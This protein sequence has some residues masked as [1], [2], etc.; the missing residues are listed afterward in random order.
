[1]EQIIWLH[2][3][4]LLILNIKITANILKMCFIY[5]YLSER[6]EIRKTEISHPL[7]CPLNSC[8]S[9]NWARLRPGSWEL[10]AILHGWQGPNY[11]DHHHHLLPPR[12]LI[13]KKLTG[14]QPFWY[15]IW[16]SQTQAPNLG[17]CC[18]IYIP[19]CSLHHTPVFVEQSQLLCV[20]FHKYF[21]IYI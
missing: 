1:M 19:I 18:V 13:S 20:C 14:T 4:Q 16:E 8:S 17:Q 21:R 15:G 9:Q 6:K 10:K 7:F 12:V 2:M 11:L 3:Y 5:F